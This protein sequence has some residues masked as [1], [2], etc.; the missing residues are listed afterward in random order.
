MRWIAVADGA[1]VVSYLA[2]T[3]SGTPEPNATSPAGWIG[4]L[5]V[6]AVAGVTA[7]RIAAAWTDGTT[8]RGVQGGE[9]R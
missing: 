7:P 9:P 8:R 3:R 1:A 4:V 2:L 5:V 6:I